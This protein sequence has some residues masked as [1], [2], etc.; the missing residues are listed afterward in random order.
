MGYMYD[1]YIVF[2]L[3]RANDLIVTFITIN[4]FKCTHKI[5]LQSYQEIT[6]KYL[7]KEEIY[8]FRIKILIR[9]FNPKH[10]IIINIYMKLMYLLIER[11]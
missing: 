3:L 4:T 7:K 10:A 6:N 5:Y 9:F 8:S 1:V 2:L 11:G